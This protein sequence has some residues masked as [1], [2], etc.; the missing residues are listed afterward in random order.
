MY[1]QED[2]KEVF[3][4]L[5]VVVFP[6]WRFSFLGYFSMLPAFRAGIPD[7]WRSPPALFTNLATFIWLLFQA[8]FV[9]SLS[10]STANATGM[11]KRFLPTSVFYLSLLPKFWRICDTDASRNTLAFKIFLYVCYH[12]VS[13]F[14]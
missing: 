3:D 13:P 4:M 14:G 6:Q 7:P 8:F 1:F 9:S 10:H 12:K 5:V 11:S 2:L